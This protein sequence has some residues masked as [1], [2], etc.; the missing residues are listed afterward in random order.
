MT[1][2]KVE[3][4]L[5][6]DKFKKYLI[7]KGNGAIISAF[8]MPDKMSWI[9]FYGKETTY[10]MEEASGKLIYNVTDWMEFPKQQI[11]EEFPAVS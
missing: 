4:R 8:F 11:S 6:D 2:I 1:W 3:D 9:A 5:P 7:K 10:W